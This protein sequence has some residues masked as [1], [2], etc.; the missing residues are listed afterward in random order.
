MLGG[1][2]ESIS[3]EVIQ[4]LSLKYAFKDLSWDAGETNRSVTN[5]K[6]PITLLVDWDHGS[7]FPLGWKNPFI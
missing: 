3:K 5:G 1:I 4:D 2:Y 6:V 7:I